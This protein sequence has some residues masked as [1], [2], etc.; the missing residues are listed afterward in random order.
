M[1]G[2]VGQEKD[3]GVTYGFR[4]QPYFQGLRYTNDREKLAEGQI[5]AR[6][7]HPYKGFVWPILKRYLP[8]RNL[9]YHT[10]HEESATKIGGFPGLNSVREIPKPIF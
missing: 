2:E 9:C 1:G 10:S 4:C 8:S 6:Y 5:M 3:D 7:R